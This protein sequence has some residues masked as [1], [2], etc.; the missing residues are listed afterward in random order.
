MLTRPSLVVF[1]M[2]GLSVLGGCAQLNKPPAD[3]PPPPVTSP[4]FTARMDQLENMLSTQCGSNLSS[5]IAQRDP[6][7]ISQNVTELS[8]Q[9]RNMR[10]D[11]TLL[12]KNNKKQVIE[13]NQQSCPQAV[14]LGEGKTV[15]GRNEWIGLPTVGTYLEA[16]IDTGAN[17]SSLSARDITP[18]ERD[19]ENWVRFK[20]GLDDKDQATEAVRNDW[21]EAPVV[22]RVKI[23]QATGEASRPVIKLLMTLGTI[24]QHIEFTLTDRTHLEFPALLGRRFL[25]DIAIVDVARQ[26]V[27]DQPVFT[28]QA[29]ETEQ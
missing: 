2:T 5:L 15:L 10:N 14:D 17:T 21:I 25:L 4:E 1:L 23:I 24:R 28:Q 13:K 18:F 8:Q 20:L 19:G 11:I 9:V 26:H 29:D 7:V 3:V 6:A 12:A 22:R 27:H 16:R